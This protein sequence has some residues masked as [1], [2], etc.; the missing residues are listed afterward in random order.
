MSIP[1][2]RLAKIEES[3]KD[4]YNVNINV[5]ADDALELVAALREARRWSFEIEDN[6]GEP[7]KATIKHDDV[8]VFI[9]QNWSDYTGEVEKLRADLAALRTA[10]EK[11]AYGAPDIFVTADSPPPHTKYI[12]QQHLR[13]LLTEPD[14]E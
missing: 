5:I 13:D 6:Y 14:H 7:T 1:D 9:G 11:L 2:N 4:R 10:V 8:A 3:A 12:D